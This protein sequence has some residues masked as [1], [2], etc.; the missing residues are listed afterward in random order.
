MSCVAKLY[1]IELKRMIRMASRTIL[2]QNRTVEAWSRKSF[3][4]L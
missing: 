1:C 3:A 4:Y 2:N